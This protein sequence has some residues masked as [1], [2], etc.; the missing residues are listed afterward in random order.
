MHRIINDDNITVFQSLIENIDWTDVLNTQNAS[1]SYDSF[2]SKIKELYNVA[3]PC[4]QIKKCK[5]ARKPWI[6]ATLL[7]RIRE[8]DRLFALFV[9]T[10]NL[11]HLLQFKRIRNRLNYDIK[12]ARCTYY[13][14][15]FASIINDPKKIWITVNDLMSRN[16]NT[17]SLELE[18]DGTLCK[19]T[20]LADKF[21]E[22]FL[23]S[24]VATITNA[25][26][27]PE[28]YIKLSIKNSIYLSP[29]SESEIYIIIK[30]LRNSK[31]CG[32]DE[33]KVQHI[34]A[35]AQLICQPLSHICNLIMST[36]VFPDKL[37]IA[38]VSVIYK[39]G[40]LNDLNNYRPISVLPVI[41]KVIEQL[42]NIR[43]YNFCKINN[44]ISEQQYGF[45]KAK[46]TELALLDIKDKII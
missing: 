1:D 40:D 7:K 35:V 29:T 11:D 39:K 34:K 5:R 23:V 2:I 3:F 19:G 6:D 46:S 32:E 14:H 13:E 22:H 26:A 43:I 41:S 16:R 17:G 21:N 8:R 28:S 30:Q 18:V 44:V 15:R 37:K 10:K 4:V 27:D 36:G 9:K 45:Q 31:A 42:I 24:G 25:T 20:V 12:K 33:I 38:K